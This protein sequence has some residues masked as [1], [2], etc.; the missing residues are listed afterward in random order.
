MTVA[1]QILIGLLV[2]RAVHGFQNRRVIP[3]V[4]T[5]K[6]LAPDRLTK[7]DMKMWDP[8]FVTDTT[9]TSFPPPS[10]FL[11]SALDTSSLWTN[12]DVWVFVAGIIPFVWAT[13]EF[14]R[15]IAVG[16]PFG[17]GSDS[18]IIGQDNNPQSSRGRRVLGKDALIVAYILFGISAGVLG[19]VLYTV[20]TNDAPPMEFASSV[21]D[22]S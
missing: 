8:S 22:A 2:L 3:R 10:F 18:V 11:T 21:G 14:W 6:T 9:S 19:L 4:V 20:I 17:T 5:A 1:R 7:V 13:I 16:E 15:R 12:S